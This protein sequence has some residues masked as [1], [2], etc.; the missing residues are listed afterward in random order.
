MSIGRS[1]RLAGRESELAALRDW[2]TRA[3][4]GAG[5]AYVIA[6]EAG[7]GKSRL[8]GEAVAALPAS[9]FVTRGATGTSRYQPG[10]AS[11]PRG[12]SADGQAGIIGARSA[13]V[14]AECVS[15]PVEG[16]RRDGEGDPQVRSRRTNDRAETASLV[17]RACQPGHPQEVMTRSHLAD[18]LAGCVNQQLNQAQPDSAE[19]YDMRPP[20][21]LPIE[22][23]AFNS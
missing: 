7:V 10:T 22:S 17:S 16:G 6:G 3:G 20:A 8:A 9:W 13:L 11:T 1:E 15:D 4:R 21:R 5:G 23:A 12:E 2:L 19:A 14:L 18:T